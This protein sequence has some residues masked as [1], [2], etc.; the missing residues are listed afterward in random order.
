MQFYGNR[1]GAKIQMSGLRVCEAVWQACAA[2]EP[3]AVGSCGARLA[4]RLRRS[5]FE[6]L[7]YPVLTKQTHDLRF[8]QLVI[9]AAKRDNPGFFPAREETVGGSH[10]E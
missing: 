5:R 6:N 3:V 2:G 1:S 7:S 8:R 4:C 10:A 9:A